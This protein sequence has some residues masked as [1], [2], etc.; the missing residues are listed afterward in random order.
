MLTRGGS[1][2]T[3]RD[4]LVFLRPPE[5]VSTIVK[6]ARQHNCGVVGAVENC[7][8]SDAVLVHRAKMDFVDELRVCE[9]VP[10][11]DAAK[12]CGSQPTRTQYDQPQL[13]PRGGSPGR[14]GARHENFSDTPGLALV[15]AVIAHAARRAD[16]SNTIAAVFDVR[17]ANFHAEE[18]SDTGWFACCLNDTLPPE[19]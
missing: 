15:K 9:V 13:R 12:K 3:S 19:T 17:Q 11:A 6:C 4:F 18:K 14:G 16:E 8:Q 5:V 1:C 7:V 10:R 2:R